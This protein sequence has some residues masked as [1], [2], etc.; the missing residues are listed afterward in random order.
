M[1]SS[2]RSRPTATLLL[3]LAA[4]LGALALTVVHPTPA[5]A[6]GTITG[7][8]VD[9]STGQGVS[10]ALVRLKPAIRGGGPGSVIASVY[11]DSNGNF[12]L[13]AAEQ[14]NYYVELVSRRY[15]S[16]HVGG[17]P[18]YLAFQPKLYNAKSYPLGTN[19]GV[20]HA[21]PAYITGRVV[22]SATGLGVNGVTVS[23]KSQNDPSSTL[24]TTTTA[25]GGYYELW[26]IDFEDDGLLRLNGTAVGHEDGYFGCG[27]LV[28][29]YALKCA[30]P[31][32]VQG[33]SIELD[34]VS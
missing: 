28:V 19:L 31:I 18:G 6:A 13:T 2:T 12:T 26:P 15:A 4:L 7:R 20:V 29:A 3:L 25:R 11:A 1:T 14:K 22:S 17:E 10:G 5:G 8:V 34:P 32:G 21:Q 30:P 9:P 27:Y 23:A 24:V 33:Q 16:G